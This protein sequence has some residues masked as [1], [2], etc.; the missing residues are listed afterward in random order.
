MATVKIRTIHGKQGTLQTSVADNDQIVFAQPDSTGAVGY[1][2]VNLTVDQTYNI[3]KKELSDI[4]NLVTIGDG[5]VGTG[6]TLDPIRP[7]IEWMEKYWISKRFMNIA[8]I[9]WNVGEAAGSVTNN[10]FWFYGQPC[11]LG[12][13][14]AEV[15]AQSWNM[16]S[17]FPNSAGRTIY[18]YLVTRNNKLEFEWTMDIRPERYDSMYVARFVMGSNNV[19]SFADH[20]QAVR[21]G[22]YRIS[23]MDT[24]NTTGRIQGG[25]YPASLGSA[26]NVHYTTEGSIVRG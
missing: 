3:V 12:G 9:G 11:H 17:I 15:P 20:V 21:F 16:A 10:V 19:V 25:T 13:V 18:L 5:L 23:K 7:N 26:A 1:R 8:Q 14:S 22:N 4:P 6:T 2:T 24:A